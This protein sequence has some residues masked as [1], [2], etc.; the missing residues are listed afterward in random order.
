MWVSHYSVFCVYRWGHKLLAVKLISVREI[1]PL[2]CEIPAST[3]NWDNA[4]RDGDLRTQEL[5][6]QNWWTSDEALSWPSDRFQC[7]SLASCFSFLSHFIWCKISLLNVLVRAHNN[8]YHFWFPCQRTRVMSQYIPIWYIF[9]FL[10]CD[11]IILDTCTAVSYQLVKHYPI[12]ISALTHPG[13]VWIDIYLQLHSHLPQSHGFW[14]KQKMQIL[15]CGIINSISL[16]L[17]MLR[18]CFSNV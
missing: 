4:F 5:K 1:Q 3:T 11:L 8:S 7:C 9:I 15:V 16:V 14:H 2:V 12:M 10:S 6:Q 18:K 13:N 17:S